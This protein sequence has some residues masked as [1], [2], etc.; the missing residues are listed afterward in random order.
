[1]S[2]YRDYL[3]GQQ[4]FDRRKRNRKRRKFLLMLILLVAVTGG[5]YCYHNKIDTPFTGGIEAALG[6][7]TGNKIS[8]NVVA[9][10]DEIVVSNA[11][12]MDWLSN[13]ISK[14]PILGDYSF[15]DKKLPIYSVD[16]DEKKIAIS[17]DAAWAEVV[18]MEQ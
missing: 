10:F 7:N 11:S 12:S 6:S 14:I 18:L 4:E 16:T 9:T 13:A 15:G 2:V 5:I 8:D 1:M 17:F 3:A